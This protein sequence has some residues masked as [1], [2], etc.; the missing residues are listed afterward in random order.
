MSE[1]KKTTEEVVE[2][3]IDQ[4]ERITNP[5]EGS[6][7]TIPESKEIKDTKNEEST[8]KISVAEGF[9]E[10]DLKKKK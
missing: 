4:Q 6:K 7:N 2:E 3:N 10:E 9:S 5:A 1:V 8:E